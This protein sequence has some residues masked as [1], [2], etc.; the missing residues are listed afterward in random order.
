MK[1]KKARD[2]VLKE[3][4]LNS[5]DKRMASG[6]EPGPIKSTAEVRRNAARKKSTPIK[7]EPSTTKNKK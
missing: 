1:E 3:E 5:S 7:A 2:I 4:V 6:Q